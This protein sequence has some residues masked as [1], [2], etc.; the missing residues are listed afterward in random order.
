MIAVYGRLWLGK[1]VSKELVKLM[2]YTESSVETK[3]MTR[4][5]GSHIEEFDQIGS[6][7]ELSFQ[8][9]HEQEK[10]FADLFNFS[11]SPM[12]L[13]NAQGQLLK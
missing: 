11:L 3:G 1:R 4:F 5:L 2:K 10:Q 8:R 12:T 6:S 13:W 9:F 7:F